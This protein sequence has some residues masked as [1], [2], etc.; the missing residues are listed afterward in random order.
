MNYQPP[1]SPTLY[2]SEK[3]RACLFRP[4]A[5]DQFCLSLPGTTRVTAIILALIILTALP[6]FSL[7]L[8]TA[9]QKAAGLTAQIVVHGA[10]L[11]SDDQGQINIAVGDQLTA[12]LTVIAPEEVKITMPTFTGKSFGDFSLLDQGPTKQQLLTKNISHSKQFFFE[13]YR[14]GPYQFPDLIINDQDLKIKG[15]EFTVISYLEG[16]ITKD[17]MADILPPEE[18]PTFI[19]QENKFIAL[20][21]ALLL[22]LAIITIFFFIKRKQPGKLTPQ[23]VALQALLD[24]DKLAPQDRP[25]NLS[26]LIRTYFD[27][28]CHLSTMS[29]TREEWQRS[30]SSLDFNQQSK[31]QFLKILQA[32]DQQQ[33]QGQE[34]N[35]TKFNEM[36]YQARLFF[37]STENQPLAGDPKACGRWWK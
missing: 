4:L 5:K 24:L 13:P 35:Q 6:C 36:I 34:I 12:T 31:E 25:H 1:T 9:E 26:R 29:Q 3:L 8:F 18:L 11:T 19:S 17:R 30:I 10:T 22:I 33:F 7:E 28:Y 16:D 15:Q 20:S 2:F 21:V 27:S 23:E 37:E 14:P 32:C